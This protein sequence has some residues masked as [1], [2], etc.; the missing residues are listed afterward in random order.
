[1]TFVKDT[2]VTLGCLKLLNQNF[3]LKFKGF[4]SISRKE[5]H[6]KIES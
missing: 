2:F 5:M 1:M 4:A 6:V 3:R